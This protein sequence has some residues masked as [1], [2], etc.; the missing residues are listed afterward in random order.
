[1]NVE[2]GTEAMRFTKKEYINGIFVA[3]YVVYLPSLQEP[4]P[5][6][7]STVSD[8]VQPFT[9]TTQICILSDFVDVS[10]RKLGKH[11]VAFSGLHTVTEDVRVWK[12]N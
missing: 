10:Q 8:L 12:I 4:A 9:C 1:M 2:I 3:V 5:R 11:F 7:T 6:P